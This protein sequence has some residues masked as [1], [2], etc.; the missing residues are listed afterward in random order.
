M[1]DTIEAG[2]TSE[3]QSL[4]IVIVDDDEDIRELLTFSL[5]NEGYGV[6]D[7]ENG[8]ECW[9]FLSAEPPPD[10]VI[11]DVMMPAMG[12]FEVL[13]KIR[14]DDRLAEIPV[15]IL[16]S[17]DREEDVVEGFESGADYYMSKPFSP[18]ELVARIQR[19]I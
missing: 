16:T 12:G 1:S 7:F 10:L 3:S 6:T 4:H 14:Q 9:E 11:L 2:G 8:R 19:V 5:R 13:K 15:I 18:R 17:R